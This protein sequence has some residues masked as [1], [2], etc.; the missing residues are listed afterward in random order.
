MKIP[1]TDTNR[2]T[3]RPLGGS[4]VIAIGQTLLLLLLGLIVSLTSHAQT[5]QCIS[6]PAGLVSWWRAEQNATDALGSNSG[7]ALNGVRYTNGP[8]G[9]AFYFDGGDDRVI[10]PHSASLNFGTGDFSIEAWIKPETAVTAF[11][12]QS[13]AN[14]RYTPNSFAAVGWEFGLIDGKLAC[15]LADAPLTGGDFSTFV[16]ASPDLRDG[17]YHH[18]ALSIQRGSSTGGKLLV[19][20]QVVLIF[21]PTSQPGD[22]STTE[23]LRIGAH[24]DASLNSHFTGAVD[25]LSIYNRALTAGEI[26]AIF[27]AGVAGKCASGSSFNPADGLV[28]HYPFSGDASDVSG[29]GNHG[30][31]GNTVL[32]VDRFGSPNAAFSFNGQNAAVTV[33]D[34]LALRSLTSNYTFNAWV[35]FGSNPQIDAAILMKSAGAGDQRKWTFWRH[36]Q[37][38]P[39]GLGLLLNR[40]PGQFQWNHNYSF[41]VGP[42]YM[43]TFSAS[44]TNCFIAVDGQV[45][46]V[47]SG[48]FGLPDTTG[49]ALSIG[50][51]EPAGNQWFDGLLDDIRI[52]NRTFTSNDIAQIYQIESAQPPPPVSCVNAPAGLVSWW[53]GEGNPDDGFGTNSGHLLGGA[54][55][56]A[57]EVGQG[58][59][60]NGIDSYVNIPSSEALKPAGPFTFE[61]WV[62]YSGNPGAISSYCIAAKG[63]DAE[64]AMDWALTVSANSRLRP[65][66][67]VN[68]GW[69]Y[70]DC[71]TPLSAGTWYHVAMVYDGAHLQGYVNGV[72]DGSANVAGLVQTSDAPLRI[73]AYAPV[74]GTGSKA[75]F[76][77]SID[78]VSFYNRNLSSGELLAVYLAGSAGKCPT[79]TNPPTGDCATLPA[80]IVS[81]WRGEGNFL[82]S[83]QS[84]HGSA[85]GGVSFVPGKAGLGMRFDGT[86]HV[87]IPHHPS[88]DC[89]NALTIELWYKPDLGYEVS[90]GLIDKRVGEAGANY[91]INLS[92]FAGLGVYYDD[93]AV[94]DGDDTVYGSV[95]EASRYLPAPA[96]GVFH[97]LAATFQQVGSN[98]VQLETYLDGQKVRTKQIAGNLAHTLNTTPVTLGST[99]RGAGE[100]FKGVMD[101]VTL[102]SRVLTAAEIQAIYGADDSGKCAAPLV[103]CTNITSG[104]VAWWQAEGDANDSLGRHHG[105]LQNGAAFAP[106]MVG[107]GFLL[108]GVNDWVGIPDAPGLDLTNEISIELWFKSSAWSANASHALVDKRTGSDCNYGIIVSQQWGL[109]LY[110]NDPAIFGGDHPGN[111]FEISA[112][113]P[114]P[115]PGVFHHFAG[116]YKQVN[117]QQIELKSYLNG[118]LIE[119]RLF[120]G[121]LAAAVNDIPLAIGAAQGGAGEFFQGVID[122][123]SLYNRV[124][125]SQEIAGIYSA[126]AAGKCPPA[127]VS[128]NFT[129]QPQNIS[130]N[131]NATARFEVV[132]AGIPT[133]NYQWFF[134]GDL[135]AGQTN[136]IL[137]L[138]NVQPAQAGSY[139]A[140]AANSSGAVTSSVATLTVL[141]H[142][143]VI[144]RQP[145]NV[146]VIETTAANL[147]AL[148]SGSAPLTYQW[149]FNGNPI[150]GGTGFSLAFRSVQFSNAGNYSVI[151][152][153]PYGTVT[154]SV[155]TLTVNPR[156]PCAS[157]HE[158]LVSWWRGENDLTDA[159]DSNN[160]TPG[161]VQYTTGKAGRTLVLPRIQV[162][163]APSLRV[164]NAL[165]LEA[166]VNPSTVSGSIPHTI[167][168]KFDYPFTG[169]G[170]Q[171]SYYLGLTNGRVMFMLSGTGSARTNTTLVSTQTLPINQ[172]SHLAATY[173]GTAMRIFINGV[174]VTKQT[175]TGG[176]F[177]GNLNL[178]LGNIPPSPAYFGMANLFAGLLD[179]VS[180]FQRALSE[181]EVQAI[182]NADLTGKCFAPPVITQQPQDQTVPLGEDVKFSLAVSGSRPLA[183]QWYFNGFGPQYRIIG[184]TNASLLIEKV[185]PNDAGH[186]FVTVTNSVGSDFSIRAQ[187]STLPAPSC[188]EILPGLISWWPGD[189]NSADV[190][191]SNSVS[192]YSPATYPT[193]KV[194]Q[195]FSFNG[196]FSRLQIN[197]SPALNFSTNA[198]FSIELW[199]KAIPTNTHYPNVPI[200]EKRTTTTSWS[201]YSLSLNQG[202]LAFAMGSGVNPIVSSFTSAGPDLRDS[203]FHHVAVTVNRDTTNGGVLYVDG[204]P[205]LTFDPRPRI[206]SPVNSS[207]L[208]I[209]SPAT[210]LSNS[211]FSGLIDEPAIYNRAL[212]A[213]EILAI[214]QAG[215][216]GKCRVSPSILTQPVGQVVNI[217]SNNKTTNATL[218]VEA[219]G[220]PLLRYQWFRNGA[221]V[222]PQQGGDKPSLVISNVQS[223]S[224]GT[225]WVRVT[226]L[227]GS[228]TSSNALLT[229]NHQPWAV[230]RHL[231]TTEDISI[232]TLLQAFDGNQ[233]PLTYV[234]VTPPTNGTLSGSAP[235]FLYTP[236]P[237]VNGGDSFIYKVNDGYVDSTNAT[238]TITIRAV[239]D[240]PVARSQI[241]TTDE[242]VA[243]PISLDASDAD[244]DALIFN[245]TAPTHGTLSGTPPYLIYTPDTNFFGEDL[246]TFTVR[247]SSN[248]VSQLAVV[249][250]TVR[251]VNDAPVAKLEITPLDALSGVTNFIALAPA[252]CDATLRLDASDSTDVEND[253]LS[254]AWVEGTNVL[255][256]GVTVTNRFKPGTHEIILLVS[257]GPN[258]IAATMT[259]EIITPA[260]G[261]AFLKTLVEEGITDRRTRPPLVNWLRQA[262]EAF[263]CCQV[264]QGVKFLEMFKERVQSRIAPKDA[265]LAAALIETATAIIEAA[266]DCDPCHRL[267]RQHKDKPGKKDEPRDHRSALP[268]SSRTTPE[269][270]TSRTR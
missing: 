111:P 160:G 97:H 124:L 115:P 71:N 116:T 19:D 156:P 67:S 254:Y 176:I 112:H 219:A 120:S 134:A 225:Y 237:N 263:E 1:L 209:G 224:S 206:G 244:G 64:A 140:V 198:D 227:F 228:V 222:A 17:N 143:P 88:L 246:F 265:E 248:A 164:T 86:S 40:V 159:W 183:Y 80:N 205:V 100:F 125:S 6:P 133:P 212:T 122:E 83:A 157:V 236:K 230:G 162:S 117:A 197:N 201:G 207:P 259:V 169:I 264:E 23:P 266:P 87:V 107:Q 16:S 15:Q 253:P 110:Y 231:N 179:E 268:E 188:T 136:A 172:W 199:I 48:N 78:E 45:V 239:N 138:N 72:L 55:Y 189:G 195:A 226:N 147:S 52:Y 128:P 85:V 2:L 75:F 66:I 108:D 178:G 270:A 60:F 84:N 65:H 150:L 213:E 204:L 196:T 223:F 234:I 130:T 251:P 89:S 109:Q 76:T 238:V 9:S 31:P 123:V 180:L 202:R 229:V 49:A 101:E 81:W 27:N 153:N 214:R 63:A 247:D 187:L 68:G 174:M 5:N 24:A 193:G 35:R 43:V 167:V 132:A 131:V 119:Q 94:L 92:G 99:A 217:E 260:E 46:T 262:G 168:S 137:L 32:A 69:H 73:G 216:A 10:V 11:G 62:R 54:T 50:G 30:V 41:T 105:T 77:G 171:S 241:I 182:Y 34:N 211:F 250:V 149:L 173:D 28:A 144:T 25:E 194:G 148:A 151:V 220:S 146:T 8:S 82:D 12:V 255:A 38:P 186:Y 175:Y 39:Y 42:W 158:G 129:Q 74:N 232:A 177:A 102:Y 95:F 181:F 58:F 93:P 103:T 22:L 215:A 252:C 106:G 256:T 114:V 3:R 145:T 269:R 20:G 14:K 57:G 218:S 36:V 155:A 104:L 210:T 91:G 47:Q 170:Q 152:T 44:A 161:L 185:R 249:S 61:A 51:A 53:R 154:S 59:G 126:A 90:Y 142:P 56:V 190:L 235:N 18:V 258:V 163:D 242:D 139:F 113:F 98:T 184:A 118:V 37:A 121:N 70:F 243:L 165:T 240:A 135:L 191:F 245:I 13:I 127:T 261:V 79:I 7:D 29:N 96:S 166:W 233:N 221:P 203:M 208:Y 26:L 33:A 192:L 4:S 257:D 267:G 21:D 141:T 200:F